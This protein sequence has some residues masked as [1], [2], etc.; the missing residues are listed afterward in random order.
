MLEVE[1]L[2]DG[3]AIVANEVYASLVSG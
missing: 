1:F 2:G 3:N